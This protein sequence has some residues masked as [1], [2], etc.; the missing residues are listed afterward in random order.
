MRYSIFVRPML[1]AVAVVF[2]AGGCGSDRGSAAKPTAPSPR[3][4]DV[5]VDGGGYAD[6]ATDAGVIAPV[7]A[8]GPL[9]ESL[10]VPASLTRFGSLAKACAGLLARSESPVL[11]NDRG[12]TITSV[13]TGCRARPVSSIASVEANRAPR[14]P[15]LVELYRTTSFSRHRDVD[16]VAA[17]PAFPIGKTEW[18]VAI[19][20]AEESEGMQSMPLG[21]TSGSVEVA[22][23][24]H[25]DLVGTDVPELVLVLAVAEPP[26]KRIDL[27]VC[28]AGGAWC[29]KPSTLARIF[30]Q[31]NDPWAEPP[32]VGSRATE[33]RVY[34]F[35]RHPR[36]V[37]VMTSG[38]PLVPHRLFP[39]AVSP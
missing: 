13:R 8:P 15:S 16:T 30:S 1:L 26:N 33:A 10:L 25:M 11:R 9:E 35:R 23:V 29:T 2:I 39:F 36:G 22:S 27:V 32:G 17:A 38:E 19:E 18:L 12:S 20:G 24:G 5:V 31:R 7:A 4:S 14:E 34:A 3:S 6:A 37:L 21:D 28:D